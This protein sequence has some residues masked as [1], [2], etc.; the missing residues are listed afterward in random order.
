MTDFEFRLFLFDILDR[1][2]FS[3][4]DLYRFVQQDFRSK[5]I[6]RQRL[7]GLLQRLTVYRVVSKKRIQ[8]HGDDRC[9]FVFTLTNEGRKR[10]AYYEKKIQ[11]QSL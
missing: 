4:S 5:R 9:R 3:C 8:D 11:E 2:E 7:Y 10:K 6:T 1:G